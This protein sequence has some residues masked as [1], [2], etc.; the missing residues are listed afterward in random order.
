MSVSESHQTSDLSKTVSTSASQ[1]S[2]LQ[3]EEEKSSSLPAG[4]FKAKL[5]S[6]G[7]KRKSLD[8]LSESHAK[9]QRLSKGTGVVDASTSTSIDIDKEAIDH[10][11]KQFKGDHHQKELELVIE[12][13]TPEASKLIKSLAQKIEKHETLHELRKRLLDET[14]Q[15]TRDEIA[16]SAVEL[17]LAIAEESLLQRSKK[18]DDTV[19]ALEDEGRSLDEGGSNNVSRPDLF[20]Q[21][22]DGKKAT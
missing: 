11:L 13:T 16:D 15:W 19:P 12:S 9:V 6:R 2:N 20:A 17:L 22:S 7:T 1:L 3:R 10:L 4:W 5:I 21:V 18:V 8:S 14:D